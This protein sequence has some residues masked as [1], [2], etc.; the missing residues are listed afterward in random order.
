MSNAR[1]LSISTREVSPTR[2]T[3]VWFSPTER[4]VSRPML[5]SQS[6]K[7]RTCWG[8]AFFL[9]ITIMVEDL[10]F[11]KFVMKKRRALQS[12]HC[13]TLHGY[14]TLH[15]FAAAKQT[16]STCVD[17]VKVVCGK[18]ERSNHG[19]HLRRDFKITV[20]IVAWFWPARK[21]ENEKNEKILVFYTRTR[22]A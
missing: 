10:R 7:R 5:R 14:P 1:I 20:G 18:S 13:K 19:R 8:S 6:V 22:P 15:L 12:F 11:Y 21:R 4:W 3:M 17:K 2:P 9:R 16:L